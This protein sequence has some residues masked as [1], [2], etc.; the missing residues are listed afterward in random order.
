[1]QDKKQQLE[2]D[3]EQWNGENWERSMSRLYIVTLL[4]ELLCGVHPGASQVALVLK[5]VIAGDIKG[6]GLIPG[7]RR[8]L[9]GGH[10]ISLQYSCLEKSTGRGTW[11]A[12]VHGIADLDM[13]VVS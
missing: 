8:S 13:T 2:L 5:I 12:T 6:M 1:M 7:S 3:M 9:G 11:W 4:I 10:G